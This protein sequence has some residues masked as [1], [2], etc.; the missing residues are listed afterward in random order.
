M[1]DVSNNPVEVKTEN[2]EMEITPKQDAK[3][4]KP[5]VVNLLVE[6]LT[7]METKLNE[8]TKPKQKV[9]RQP[10]QKQLENLAKAREKR[11]ANMVKRKEIKK[12]IKIKEKKIVNQKLQ[13]QEKASVADKNVVIK[14][15]ENNVKPEEP[16]T[17]IHTEEQPKPIAEP[18]HP[19]NPNIPATPL[20]D[21]QQV[22]KPSFNFAAR[23]YR[24]R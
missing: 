16:A 20:P 7:A 14:Q 12:E 10:T 19:N 17:P 9:K 8:A 18:T 21:L 3:T 2:V 23:P 15:E 6:K 1:E 4:D 5:D 22:K 11:N 24:R 13:E